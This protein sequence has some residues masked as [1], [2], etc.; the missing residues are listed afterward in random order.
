MI[1]VQMMIWIRILVLELT[2]RL[3]KCRAIPPF[4]TNS[5]LSNL[6]I[7]NTKKRSIKIINKNKNYLTG[8]TQTIATRNELKTTNPVK[9]SREILQ[10]N[11]YFWH[12]PSRLK[13][14]QIT[15][16]L[17]VQEVLTYFVYV[18][19]IWIFFG[20][21]AKTCSV[22]KSAWIRPLTRLSRTPIRPS[23]QQKYHHINHISSVVN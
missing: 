11:V 2:N 18:V 16:L 14:Q 9:I 22:G 10:T 6:G 15:I 23:T 3:L 8:V 21:F 17:S 19:T 20:Q 1:Q 5:S 7:C 13:K 4:S 12:Q